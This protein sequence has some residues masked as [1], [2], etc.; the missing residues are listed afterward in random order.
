[1]SKKK[2]KGSVKLPKRLM[3][4][5]IPKDLRSTIN[6]ALKEVPAHTLKPLLLSAVGALATGVLGRLSGEAEGSRPAPVTG[7][8][9][10]RRKDEP[11]LRH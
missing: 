3:G 9:T 7:A 5:K 4:V 1:M 2:K 11:T 10:A 6:A 8:R